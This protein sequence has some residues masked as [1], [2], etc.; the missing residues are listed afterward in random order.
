MSHF[1]SKCISLWIEYWYFHVIVSFFF[2][3]CVVPNVSVVFKD[4]KTVLAR[5]TRTER[6]TERERDRGRREDGLVVWSWV[7]RHPLIVLIS[8]NSI[9]RLL[10]GW[11]IDW[12]IDWF[13]SFFFGFFR[14]VSRLFFPPVSCISQRCIARR[15]PVRSGSRG[16]GPVGEGER[17]HS[18]E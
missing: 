4:S 6:E 8:I 10:S 16:F 5:R 3:F 2:S 18:I 1:S 11:L 7:D 9:L 14:L 15:L 17:A 13:F 12:L